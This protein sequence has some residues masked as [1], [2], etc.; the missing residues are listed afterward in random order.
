MCNKSW[1]ITAEIEVPDGNGKPTFVYNFLSIDRPTFMAKDPL[2][3][4]KH[5]LAV[6]FA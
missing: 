6:N 3:K 2:P 1:T 4:G 5:K